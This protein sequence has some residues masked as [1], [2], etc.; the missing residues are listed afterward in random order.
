MCTFGHHK[1]LH[2]ACERIY[3]AKAAKVHFQTCIGAII[4]SR[5]ITFEG[6]ERKL[7]RGFFGATQGNPDEEDDS[8]VGP[9]RRATTI[10]MNKR[11]SKKV[12]A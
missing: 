7:I 12:I 11:R 3:G 8:A 6:P 1:T 4:A 2:G 10:P 9:L 5:W